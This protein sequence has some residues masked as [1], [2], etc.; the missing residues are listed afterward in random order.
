MLYKP[1]IENSQMMIIQFLCAISLLIWSNSVVQCASK[2]DNIANNVGINDAT[3]MDDWY[4]TGTAT[5]QKYV[6]TWGLT[7]MWLLNTPF[8]NTAIQMLF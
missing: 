4:T 5:G 1:A 7:F 8:Q 3:M 6:D 2:C